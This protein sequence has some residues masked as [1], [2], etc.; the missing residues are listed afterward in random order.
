MI[1]SSLQCGLVALMAYELWRERGEALLSRWPT[2]IL[3]ATHTVILIGRMVLVM[4]TP[5]MSHAD[6]FR[7]PIFAVMAFGRC[8]TPSPSHSCSCR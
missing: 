1:V 4:T 8:S 3:L 6:L 2:I 7:S 5:I